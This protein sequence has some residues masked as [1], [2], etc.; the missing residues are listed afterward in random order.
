MAAYIEVDLDPVPTTLAV[1]EEII[2]QG[3][4]CIVYR[5]ELR[6][7]PIAVKRIHEELLPSVN[8]HKF[9]E[10]CDRMT[11]VRHPNVIGFVGVYREKRSLI[12]VMELMQE[13][14]GTYLK[15][16]RGQPRLPAER[17]SAICCSVC[18]GGF[19][20]IVCVLTIEEWCYNTVMRCR[21]GVS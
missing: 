5:G 4:H 6:S 9:K 7:E 14:L 10:E 17:L 19:C 15:R 8:F 3:S 16:N 21:M 1:K 12:L 2:G 11:N 13:D 20:G 18:E